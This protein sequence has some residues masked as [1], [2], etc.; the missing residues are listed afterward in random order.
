MTR[1]DVALF[2]A[3]LG[4]ISI[5]AGLVEA[6][7]YGPEPSQADRD[8]PI[9][10]MNT[11]G[12]WLIC[13]FPEP[14]LPRQGF[15]RADPRLCSYP[16]SEAETIERGSG[17]EKGLRIPERMVFDLVRP[18]GKSPAPVRSTFLAWSL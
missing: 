4:A 2:A 8:R 9:L 5:A 7:I 17:E 16:V 12:R 15:G 11:D 18:L 3:T 14:A 6:D 13:F 10:F 1:V